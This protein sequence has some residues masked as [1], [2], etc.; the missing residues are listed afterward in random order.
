MFSFNKYNFEGQFYSLFSFITLVPD[1]NLKYLF[2][3]IVK[4][5]FV[6]LI[7][8]ILSFLITFHSKSNGI[9]ITDT[10]QYVRTMQKVQFSH[11]VWRKICSL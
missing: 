2:Y 4:K 9:Q 11:V 10:N 6:I 8:E 1:V 3:Q 5:T 7:Q